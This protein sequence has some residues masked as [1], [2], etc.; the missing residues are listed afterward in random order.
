MEV[1]K[2]FG[3]DDFVLPVYVQFLRRASEQYD[4][5]SFP[6]A[7]DMDSFLLN[8]HDIDFSMHRA[9]RLAQEEHTL[10]LS[11][12]YFLHLH[13]EYYNLL[14]KDI[15]KL[16]HGIVALGHHVG[17]HFD[18]HYHGIEDESK[19]E[20]ELD[21]ER[22]VIEHVFDVPCEVFLSQYHS[23]HNGLQE[24]QI[25]GSAYHLCHRVSGWGEVLFRQQRLLV[26]DGLC[27][28]RN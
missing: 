22:K 12:T 2:Q 27:T 25:C 6:Q 24:A 5:V 28:R 20:D 3:F 15:S 26:F 16:V 18:T 1:K 9:L 23:F 8:R 11:S 7:L 17:V 4:F 10:G 13:S 14:D 21:W 19:L